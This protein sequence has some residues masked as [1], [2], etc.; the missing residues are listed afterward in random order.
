MVC[1]GGRNIFYFCAQTAVTERWF[2]R[3]VKEVD[4]VT[5][6]GGEKKRTSRKT[7]KP[8]R[9]TPHSVSKNNAIFPWESP[10]RP[11]RTNE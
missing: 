10:L 3:R 11:I 6:G 4:G 1:A 2:E 8:I 9:S 5:S 7:L